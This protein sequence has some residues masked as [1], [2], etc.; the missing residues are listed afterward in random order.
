MAITSAANLATVGTIG[1]GV[2]NGT[3]I[4]GSYIAATQPNIDSIGTDGDTLDILGDTL[5]ISNTT[6]QKP[7]ISLINQTDDTTGPYLNFRN[8]RLDSSIQAG[9]DNDDLGVIG[10]WGYDDQG[11]PALQRYASIFAEIHDATSGEESGRLTFQVANH[12]GGIG[13]G[14]ILTGGS[15]DDEIDVTVGLGTASTTTIAGDLAVTGHVTG[16]QYRIYNTSFRQ[17]IG[18]TK[19]YVPLKSQDEQT[20]LTREEISELSVCDGRVA[21]IT[22]RTEVLNTHSGDA[23]VTFGV[24]TN[25]VGSAYSSGFSVIE[26]EDVTINNADDQ[27]VF[28]AVF[29]TTKHWD[30]TDMFAVSIQSDTDISGSNERFFI[31][32]VIEDDWS[33]YLAGSTRE[34][35]STP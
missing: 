30:S 35:D 25:V 15:A 3:A 19:Y 33:T 29:D 12:D 10:F 20:V 7:E 5:S 27:H 32:V 31:T 2:W 16:K 11:T 13:S 18:T 24:E 23:T 28:H 21:S 8:Q 9:E 17:D 1:T 26:T 14:L 22:L 6:S 34:I 4:G